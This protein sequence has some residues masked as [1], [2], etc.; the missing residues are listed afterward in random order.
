[1][2]HIIQKRRLW[3]ALSALVL[4]PSVVFL[5]M[6]GLKL[7]IDFTGGTL[8]KIRFA[9]ER[10]T[11][12]L[13]NERLTSY[14]LGETVV[15]PVDTQDMAIRMAVVENQKREETLTGLRETFGDV[16]EISFESI[17]PTVGQELRQRSISAIIFVLLGIVLY[18]TW[19]FRKISKSSSIPSWVLGGAAII[20]LFHDLLIILGVYAY[21]GYAHGIE[22]GSLFVTALLTILG[23]SVHDTI[24]VFD[25]VRENILQARSEDFETT[26][27]ASVNQTLVRSL[28]TSLTTLLVLVALFFFGGESIRWFV[29]AMIVGIIVGTY[30]S[31]FIASPLL[32]VW[33]KWR[34]R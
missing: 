19:A 14:G 34:R 33:Q 30:S 32:V 3:F 28:N 18:V 12:Q 8:W 11:A 20:A 1:M 23:F 17:G 6:G 24:V 7:N 5:A 9:G 2:F 22:V 27:N 21:L 25:R 4:I 13:V 10:P 29:F 15:Q 26:I 16:E 31:I